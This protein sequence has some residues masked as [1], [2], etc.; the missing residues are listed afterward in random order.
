MEKTRDS[1]IDSAL[2]TVTVKS[3]TNA[4]DPAKEIEKKWPKR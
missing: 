4:E 3:Q 1:G 2:G